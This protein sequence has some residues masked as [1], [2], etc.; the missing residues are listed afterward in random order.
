[1]AVDLDYVINEINLDQ[2]NLLRLEALEAENARLRAVLEKIQSEARSGLPVD[3][4]HISELRFYQAKV[5]RI[6]AIATIALT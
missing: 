3:G 1:M 4:L 2:D 5:R 6:A